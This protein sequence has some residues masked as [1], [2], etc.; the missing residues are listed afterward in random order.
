MKFKNIILI[1]LL[2]FISCAGDILEEQENEENGGS[3]IYIVG[4]LS[5]TG[6]GTTVSGIDVYYPETDSWEQNITNIPVPV[7][8]AGITEFDG[9]IYVIGGYTSGGVLSATNQIYDISSNTW[10]EGSVTGF[11][12]RAHIKACVADGKIYIMGGTANPATS[13]TWNGGVTVQEYTIG[14]NWITKTTAFSTGSIADRLILAFNNTI[15]NMGGRSAVGTPLTTHDGYYLSSAGALTGATELVLPAARLGSA[16]VL[17]QPLSG[18]AK[19]FILGG[20]QAINNGQ[21]YILGNPTTSTLVNTVYYLTYPFTSPAAW[22]AT[23]NT[24]PQSLALGSAVITDSDLYHFGG[25]TGHAS[26]VQSSVYSFNMDSVPSG[27]WSTKTNMP[28]GRIGHTAVV[29]E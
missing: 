6:I 20:F 10:S 16:A 27:S 4:G 3:K 23:T 2:M 29:V 18:S 17:Y 26:G 14:G 13:T 5:G 28:T 25:T 8:F 7:S 19:M 11:V 15:Y 22:T 1:L 9:K 24:L 12:A 21:N